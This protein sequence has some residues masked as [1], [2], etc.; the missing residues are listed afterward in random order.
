MLRTLMEAPA[1]QEPALAAADDAAL[2]QFVRNL[3]VPENLDD[4]DDTWALADEFKD[5]PAANNTRALTAK[6]TPDSDEPDWYRVRITLAPVG[7]GAPIVGRVYFLIHHTFPKNKVPAVA[8]NGTATLER[9]AYGAF[10]VVALADG[11][12]TKLKLDLAQLP[13]LPQGFAE[14]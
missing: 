13:N 1:E 10:T 12:N 4:E 6:V 14:G 2:R 9:Y 11:G 8:S 5:L 3:K 7:T